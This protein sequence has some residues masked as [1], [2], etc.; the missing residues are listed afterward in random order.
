MVI[1]EER[2]FRTENSPRRKLFSQIVSEAF[3]GTPYAHPP[4]GS[5]ADIKSL[6][7]QQMRDYFGTYYDPANIVIVVSGD[8]NAKELMGKMR[9]NFGKI[10]STGGVPE[11]A[12]ANDR[13]ELYKF[14]I[15]WKRPRDIELYGNSPVPIFM[16]A[17]PSFPKGERNSYTLDI[18]AN[19]LGGGN[20]SHFTQKYVHGPKPVLGAMSV[21]NYSM[22]RGGILL[23]SGQ[24]LKGKSL[25]SFRKNFRKDLKRFCM[26]AISDRA[27]EK[28]KNQYL[29]DYFGSFETNRGLA[30]IV[31]EREVYYGDPFY[32]KQEL[33]DYLSVSSTEVQEVCSTTLEQN[34]PL[35]VSVWANHKKGGQP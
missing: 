11:E 4:I 25:R 19:I 26:T 34:E 21:F 1:L 27:V 28:A 10:V 29:V 16:A 13:K 14:K 32:F 7:P 6:S 20:S 30:Q 2:K 3:R 12:I 22:Q 33:R 18:L 24:L 15:N 8:F 31:G 35:I 5:V 9:K 23:F 17:Y